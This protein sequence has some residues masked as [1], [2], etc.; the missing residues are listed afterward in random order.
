MQRV[1]EAVAD[2][3]GTDAATLTELV[4]ENFV[5]LVGDDPAFAPWAE[6][7]SP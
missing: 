4:F 6:Y 7:L 2:V 5:R 1:L 3:R